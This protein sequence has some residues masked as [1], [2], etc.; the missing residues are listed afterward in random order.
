MQFEITTTASVPQIVRSIDSPNKHAF[1]WDGAAA[2][3]TE[4][5]EVATFVIPTSYWVE[6]GDK[7]E[8]LKVS[9]LK[10]RVRNHYNAWAGRDES[11]KGFELHLASKP[12][13][14][15]LTCYVKRVEGA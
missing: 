4:T 7:A 10:T 2:K 13:S 8:D 3:V 6:R 11:R 15:D 9:V 14:T 1:P 12:G 5:G